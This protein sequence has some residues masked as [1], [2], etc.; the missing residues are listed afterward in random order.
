MR[1]FL[2][3]LF[4][5]LLVLL[6]GVG[7]LSS[8][9]SVAPDGRA[10]LEHVLVLASEDM[11]GRKS[12]TPEYDRAAEYVAAKMKEYGLKPAGE[13]GT[14]FQSVPFKNWTHFEQPLRLD[15]VS[16]ERRRYVPG[17]DRDFHPVAGAGSGKLRAQPVFAGF[18][19]VSEKE[20]WNE[21]RDL[22]VG[23][24]IVVVV[25]GAPDALEES[26]RK[27][28]TLLKKA[29]LAAENGA[30]G[31]I[32]IEVA[33]AGASPAGRRSY[34]PPW[35][36]GSCPEGFLVVRAG[37]NFADD[38][39]YSARKSWR[40]AVSKT[41]RLKRP[42]P[43]VLEGVEV[44]ME[45]H[46]VAGERTAANV[47]GVLPG[48]DKN[49]KDEILIIGG[50]L[51]HLGV[52]LD[53]FVYPGA[54]DNACSAAVILETAR[55]LQAERFR[56]RRT[57]CFASWAGE[58]LG[59]VGSRYYLEH[60]VFPLEKTVAYLNIDMV[61]VGDADLYVGGMWEYGRFYELLKRGLSPEIQA[62]LHSRRNYRGSDHSAFWN[63]GVTAVS[64]RTG[65][66]LTRGL[67]DEHPEYHRPGDRAEL[68]DPELLALAARYH[69][70]ALKHLAQ[71]KDR[72]MDN[73]FRTEFLHK[74]ADVIDLHCDT[75]GRFLRGE[76]LRKDLP[77]GHIDIPKLKRGAVDL[78]VFACFTGAP[79]SAEERERDVRDTFRQIDAVRRLAEENPDDL[80]VVR[81]PVEYQAL[82]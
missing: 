27:D 7:A 12:G 23:G 10:A 82:I 50:H 1:R 14:Y 4:G 21:Y 59:L 51:D 48:T 20:G 30:A 74:D 71:T 75:I 47:L 3:G 2:I 39:F 77:N 66:L 60:P 80:A 9:R 61:G 18:G 32:E 11:K 70:E 33:E 22:D 36:P 53:G 34:V 55:V 78:Q 16:G 24:K 13:K 46:Y 25:E 31:M 56:P 42:H 73:D 38:L 35:P 28:W 62:L 63:K 17:R 45:V 6:S 81:S 68:V 49:L 5:A 26:A 58:E 40:D 44:E 76:D 72:L 15:I 67:D 43:L 64:L 54:D 52:R 41:L 37:R 57:I 69:V 8:S 65:E 79:E 29:K 19:V